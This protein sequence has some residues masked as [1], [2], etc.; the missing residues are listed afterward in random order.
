MSQEKELPTEVSLEDSLK[1]E[2][3]GLKVLVQ[4]KMLADLQE[5]QKKLADY[6]C[7][8]YSL[9]PNTDDVDLKTRKINRAPKIEGLKSV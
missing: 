2:N 4:Q 8:T 5:Q 6:M 7:Q 3:I 1:W 9:D